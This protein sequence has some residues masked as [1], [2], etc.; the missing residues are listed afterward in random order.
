MLQSTGAVHAVDKQSRIELPNRANTHI[1][2]QTDASTQ[3]QMA[4][5]GSEMVKF[6]SPYLM[7][8]FEV[9]SED[10]GKYLGSGTAI[11][12]GRMPY[13]LTAAHVPGEAIVQRWAH[14]IGDKTH[15]QAIHDAW[16]CV[17]FPEDLAL[18]RLER[19]PFGGQHRVRM[20]P[21][22]FLDGDSS[23]LEND[24]LFVHGVPEKF[25]FWGADGIACRTFP[26][27]TIVGKSSRNWFD[28][29]IHFGLDFRVEDQSDDQGRPGYVPD[30]HGMS[31]STVWRTNWKQHKSKW[32][33][34]FAR[35]VG[36]THD[37]D[38]NGHS[39]TCTIQRDSVERNLFP[40]SPGQFRN[41][42]A[43]FCTHNPQNPHAPNDPWYDVHEKCQAL[44]ESGVVRRVGMNDSML[45]LLR[46][47]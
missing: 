37:W 1:E 33:P 2:M 15:P 21:S 31:G 17:G 34:E 8:V 39:I 5:V 12:L 16:H 3:K 6:T 11:G 30:P 36:I 20:L 28:R 22:E 24:F 7:Q 40:H 25:T 32:R 46:A 47:C 45:K 38:T 29:N 42:T 44:I 18:A 14:S 35:V 10:S 26:Y 19:E 41:V 43:M 27:I 23:D 9:E 4:W 13:L